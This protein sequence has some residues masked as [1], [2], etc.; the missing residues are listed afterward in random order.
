MAIEDRDTLLGL[1]KPRRVQLETGEILLREG[2]SSERMYVLQSGTLEVLRRLDD[3]TQAVIGE[4][5]E[6]QLA[7]EISLLEGKP[8]SA[9]LRAIEPCSLLEVGREVLDGFDPDRSTPL[10]YLLVEVARSL[11]SHLRNSRDGAVDAV[12]RE[13]EL[14]RVRNAMA[15]FLLHM[16]LGFAAYA[17]AMKYFA[18]QQLTLKNATVVTGPMMVAMCAT[19]VAFGRHS[20][21][22][23][24]SFGL[25]WDDARAHVRE[26]LL[27]TLPVLGL[28]TLGKWAMVQLPAYAG[29]PVI[30]LL[31]R[32]F[33]LGP[34]LGYGVYSLLV[35]FQEFLSRGA[36]QGPLY[37]F[38]TGSDR[39]RWFWAIVVSNTLFGVTHLHLTINYGVAAFTGGVLWGVLYARQRS[40]VGPVISHVIVGV[41]ALY[42]LG[43]ADILKGIAS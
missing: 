7:G 11:S 32:P 36:I 18:S 23:A 6:G 10:E 30:P 16:L 24:R 28:L 17:V 3:G 4:M 1:L 19:A 21:L 8:H 2:E 5:H 31:E 38:F 35:P 20:G 39:R 33:T 42:V 25:H 14:S 13:L 29:Q 12:R 15:S 27:W 41:Y 9:T 43:F 34:L 37:E 22:S 26:A 40:L